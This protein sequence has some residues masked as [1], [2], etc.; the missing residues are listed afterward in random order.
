[1]A[2]CNEKPCKGHLRS[3]FDANVGVEI[4]KRRLNG[5]LAALGFTG[6]T[7]VVVGAWLAEVGVAAATAA[8]VTVFGWIVVGASAIAIAA[9]ALQFSFYKKA[10]NYRNKLC[11]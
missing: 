9:A 11:R 1:M 7:L 6:L 3:L 2:N 4:R 10:L 8:S 5:V